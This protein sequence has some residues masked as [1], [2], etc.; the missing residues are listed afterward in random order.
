MAASSVARHILH[1]SKDELFRG[2]CT[3]HSEVTTVY[4]G[5]EHRV[6]LDRECQRLLTVDP[7]EA[8]F[9]CTATVLEQ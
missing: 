7:L 5:I 8:K 2:S 1:T 3:R 6:G 9:C 4:R